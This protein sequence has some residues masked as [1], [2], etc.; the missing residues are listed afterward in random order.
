MF[1]R[2]FWHSLQGRKLIFSQPGGPHSEAGLTLIGLSSL[3]TAGPLLSPE[4]KRC[5]EQLR[6]TAHPAVSQATD[7]TFRWEIALSNP[8]R[9]L[10]RR[11][12]QYA[13]IAF[14]V[15]QNNSFPGRLFRR[16]KLRDIGFVH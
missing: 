3:E 14:R 11:F 10:C 5:Q 13:A 9:Q 12:F 8:E 7:A 6:A 15:I 1:P 2:G 16:F 4:R